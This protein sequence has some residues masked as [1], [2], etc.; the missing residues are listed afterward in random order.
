M[1]TRL[2]SYYELI[3][4]KE[5]IMDRFSG[6]LAIRYANVELVHLFTIAHSF[7][8]LTI[9]IFVFMMLRKN[10]VFEKKQYFLVMGTSLFVTILYFVSLIGIVIKGTTNTQGQDA[11]IIIETIIDFLTQISS[12]AFSFVFALLMNFVL[13]FFIFCLNLASAVIS[14]LI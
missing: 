1:V 13:I 3:N 9:S 2:R 12:G 11:L 7:T 10:H 14:E 6:S 8:C 5:T 4:Y